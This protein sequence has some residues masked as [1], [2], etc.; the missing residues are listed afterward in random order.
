MHSNADAATDS[1]ARDWYA[2]TWVWRVPGAYQQVTVIISQVLTSDDPPPPPQPL[3]VSE[4]IAGPAAWVVSRR[5]GVRK[6]GRPAGHRAPHGGGA[7]DC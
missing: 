6:P 1:A 3:S 5:T 2:V 4:T 7:A